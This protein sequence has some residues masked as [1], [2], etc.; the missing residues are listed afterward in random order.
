MKQLII[1]AD[2]LGIC[3]STNRAIGEAFRHG[4]LT[5]ASLMANGPAFDHAVESVIRPN[6]G[7]GIGLH[8]CLTG[9]RSVSP[10]DDVPAL[11]NEDG[12]FRHGF[13]SLLRLTLTKR[14]SAIEQVEREVAA[15]FEKL[16]AHAVSIDH[17]DSH[18]HVH[19]IPA[20]FDVIVRLARHYGCPAIRI[21]HEPLR[22]VQALT[23]P[24][25]LPL[26]ANNLPKKVVLS[27]LA[28][29]NRRRTPCLGSPSRVYGILGSGKMDLGRVVDAIQAAGSAASEIITHPGGCDPDLD[30]TLS[31]TDR[32]FLRSPNR[33]IEFEAL[34]N[35]HARAALDRAN[36]APARYQDLGAARDAVDDLRVAPRI[37]WKSARIGKLPR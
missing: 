4:V 10:P 9:G 20:M 1:N 28:L 13:L 36:V 14:A 7:L 8:I 31:R 23:R 16:R 19:M 29:R 24:S 22:A 18:R 32:Q 5:S 30:G 27:L 2:D 33:G 11:V 15:Q 6:P 35:P 25:Q 21:S 34:V 3:R 17:V 37:T 26:L 12:R